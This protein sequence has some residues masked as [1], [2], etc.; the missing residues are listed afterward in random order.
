MPTVQRRRV[1]QTRRSFLHTAAALS[2]SCL[3]TPVRTA[4][5]SSSAAPAPEDLVTLTLA[6]ASRRIHAHQLTSTQLTEAFLDPHR[7]LQPQAQRLHHRH[8]RNR[9]RPGQ[10][11]RRRSESRQLPRPAA[12]HPHRPQGQHRHRRHPAPPPPARSST[13]RVPTED[14]FVTAK[15]KQA[16]AIFLGKANMHEF[17]MGH[18]SASTYFGPVRNPWAPDHTPA[19]SSGGCAVAVISDLC[20][21]AVGTDTGGSVRMPAAWCSMV[22]FKP[23]Y[24]LVSIRGIVPLTYSLDHCGPMTRNVAD[25]AILLNAMAGYDKLDVGSVEHPARRLH[26]NH[27][28]ARQQAPPRHPP[29]PLLRPPRA[30]NRRRRRSRHQGPYR[31]HRLH[32]GRPAPP[33]PAASPPSPSARKPRPTTSSFIAKAKAA[34]P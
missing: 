16:G 9:P 3:V 27:E 30:R 26:P 23:T 24:G 25:A 18:T 28:A 12:R 1:S 29:R 4:F 20:T 11:P 2:A 32:Q 34:T 21:A 13:T 5:A 7:H 33:Q 19:G 8:A 14:A 15:L 17:A 6:E 22:G 31:P 10:S